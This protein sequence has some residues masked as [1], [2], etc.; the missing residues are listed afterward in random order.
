MPGS[1]NRK[2]LKAVTKPTRPVSLA[3]GW[4]IRRAGAVE[5]VEAA[6]LARLPWL[7]H[8]FTLRTGGASELDGAPVLNL[9]RTDWDTPRAVEENRARLLGALGGKMS[10]VTQRQFHS[11][12]VR[13]FDAPP[14]EA[15]RGDAVITGTPG[16][17]LAVLTA[18]CIPILLADTKRRVIAAIHAGWRGTLKRIAAKTLGRMTLE[19]GTRPRDVVAA[20]GPG[21]GRC[22]Y[23]VGIE[24]VQAFHAQFAGARDFFE[25]PFDRL[26]ADDSPNPLQW[27][28]MH[29]PGHQPPPPR[30]HLDLLAANRA[31]LAA[32]GVPARNL[33]V[34][35]LCTAC[36]TD[37]LFS[38]RGEHGRTGRLMGVIG[39][40]K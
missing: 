30:A 15:L 9:G 22:C 3:A 29:P 18:D 26:V 28:N 31:Q 36:H 25:G 16:L 27:L 14:A 23:E 20:L 33:H 34:S 1:K 7:V 38:H 24:V 10:L 35:N 12:M 37:L 21:I 2:R 5:L 40:R 13:R 39:I 4:R 11:D 6:A 17:L 32:A 19:F 8:G